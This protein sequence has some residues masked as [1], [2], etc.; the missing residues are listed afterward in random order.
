MTLEA[1]E[2]E[3]MPARLGHIEQAT[4][5]RCEAL[6]TQ[7]SR[8]EEFAANLQRRTVQLTSDTA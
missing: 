7:L 5:E 6:R 2:R 3:Q 1:A 8:A 4:R